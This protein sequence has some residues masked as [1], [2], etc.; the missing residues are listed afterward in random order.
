M[1][2]IFTRGL[3]LAVPGALLLGACGGGGG[4]GDASRPAPGLAALAVPAVEAG[5]PAS[6]VS[7]GTLTRNAARHAGDGL[8]VNLAAADAVAGELDADAAGTAL[9]AVG[10]GPALVAALDGGAG[11]AGAGE[12]VAGLLDGPFGGP[13]GDSLGGPGA[14]GGAAPFDDA[15]SDEG[16]DGYGASF[17][18][19]VAH[20]LGER[21]TANMRRDGDRVEIDPDEFALCA[22]LYGR[23]YHSETNRANCRALGADL[24]VVVE[25]VAESSGIVTWSFRDEPVLRAAYAPDRADYE[26][27]LSGLGTYLRAAAALAGAPTIGLGAVPPTLE[28]TLRLATE[29]RNRAPGAEAGSVSF[30]VGETLRVADPA[31]GTRLELEPSTLFAIAADAA[32]GDGSMGVTLGAFAA[33]IGV[34]LGGGRTTSFAFSHGGAVIDAVRDG[35]SGELELARYG[36]P[37]A[38]LAWSVDGRDVARVSMPVTGARIGRGGD[39]VVLTARA[40]PTLE[41][42]GDPD[43]GQGLAFAIDVP[44]G[45]RLVERASGDL[46]VREGGPLVATLEAVRADG[47]VV[48]SEASVAAGECIDRDAPPV[49]NRLFATRPCD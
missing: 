45:T 34:D 39:S 7:T 29:V 23:W 18:S 6:E 40:T 26:L 48:R 16:P 17:G 5:P 19:F 24:G 38:P 1:A 11:P 37:G 12:L 25:A 44:A 42:L 36:L 3:A 41:L 10:V 30:G 15:A 43:T 47:G 28:G 4:D 32:T 27:R 14:P 35:A 31:L 46:E 22:T 2:T 9:A 8:V 49:A 21:G 20:S 33:S 13:M